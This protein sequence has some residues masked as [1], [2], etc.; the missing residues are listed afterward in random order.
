MR[1]GSQLVQAFGVCLLVWGLQATPSVAQRPNPE[2]QPLPAPADSVKLTGQVYDIDS[3]A[4]QGLRVQVNDTVL[5]TNSQG[6]WTV[7]LPRTKRYKLSIL[8]ARTEYYFRIEVDSGTDR[9][10]FPVAYLQPVQVS[11][12]KI[13]AHRERATQNPNRATISAQVVRPQDLQRFATTDPIA[14]LTQ[15]PGVTVKDGQPSIR[16]SSGYTYGAGTRVITCLNGLPLLT[17]DRSSAPFELLPI[18]NIERIE[19]LK[20][21]SSVVYGAGAMG[22]VF[23]IVTQVPDTPTT[24]LRAG[25]T[26]YDQ[27]A[28][29]E[30]DWDGPASAIGRFVN[31]SHAEQ[32]G[33]WGMT[34]L[35]GLEHDA[36]FQEGVHTKTAR[37]LMTNRF[38]FEV[39]FLG[40]RELIVGL[41]GQVHLD[42]SGILLA[43]EGYPDGALT[44]A[45][46]RYSE[47]YVLK[48]H[49]DPSL[50]LKRPGLTFRYRSRLYGQD[51]YISTGQN[52]N[53]QTN[54]HDVSLEWHPNAAVTLVGGLNLTNSTVTSDSTFGRQHPARGLSASRMAAHP[55]VEA[56]SGSTVPIRAHT[57]RYRNAQ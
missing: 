19:V 32:V 38:G 52:A 50:T 34:L 21:A 41:D 22:G 4:A 53:A 54:Q 14:G 40:F 18:D 35:A 46:D 23:N 20:G 49:L 44:P 13:V 29:S 37:V 25:L 39:D 51:Q 47:Q 11:S 43:W 17:G 26:V 1:S 2:A 56:A 3:L 57:R 24:T 10:V 30:A 9:I 16:G 12:L 5:F 45:P 42:S 8:D 33:R 36:G 7:S 15:V 31:L 27:P 48:R 6:E 55:Q 28:I